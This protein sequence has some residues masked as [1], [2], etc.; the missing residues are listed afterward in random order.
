MKASSSFFLCA[1]LCAAV[2]FE[3]LALERSKGPSPARIKA[4]NERIAREGGYVTK[5]A[6]GKFVLFV[7]TL[8]ASADL[9]VSDAIGLISSRTRLLIETQKGDAAKS[10]RPDSKYGAVITIVNKPGEPTL[11]VAPEDA[12]GVVNVARLSEGNVDKSTYESR[13]IKEIWRGFAMVMG[14]SNSPFQPCLMR[15]VNGPKDL[16]ANP[17]VTPA[18]MLFNNIRTASQALGIG[19]EVRETYLSACEHGWAPLPTNDVQ[20]T[21]WEKVHTLPSKPLK[22]EK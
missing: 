6:E 11:L 2:S 15:Q 7:N 22:L 17:M 12:W 18:P 19:E 16:D 1:A 20:K 4:L 10:Y 21:I 9:A 8:D 13:I 5:K 3:A 14:A